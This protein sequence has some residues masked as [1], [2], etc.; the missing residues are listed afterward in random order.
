M[1]R[2]PR[3]FAPGLLYHVIVR[4]NQRRKTFRSDHDYKAYLDRLE[5]YHK[6]RHNTHYNLLTPR[7]RP[8]ILRSSCSYYS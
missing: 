5:I 2:R 4:G 8:P 1:A 3:V 7:S 6:V